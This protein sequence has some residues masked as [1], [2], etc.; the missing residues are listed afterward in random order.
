[1][2]KMKPQSN[3]CRSHNSKEDRH[4]AAITGPMFAIALLSVAMV[5]GAEAKDCTVSSEFHLKQSQV[6][7]GVLQDP[8]G[9][10][11]SGMELELLSGRKMLYHVRA[12][13]QGKYNFGEVRAGKYRL[14]V[15]HA[16]NPFCAPAVQCGDRGCSFDPKLLINPKNAIVIN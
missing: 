11:L 16:G 3:E 4:A 2:L 8:Y 14:R 7:S 10:P 12:D 6:F 1:M 15:R 13:N 9:A 5:V